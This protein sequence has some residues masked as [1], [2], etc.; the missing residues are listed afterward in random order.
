[1]PKKRQTPG[2]T[3]GKHTSE[4][5]FVR[6]LLRGEIEPVYPP[7]FEDLGLSPAEVEANPRSLIES[8]CGVDNSQEVEQYDG[9]LGVTVGF[10]ASN[11]RPVGQLQ[12]NDNL[13]SIYTNPGNV[14]GVR[15]GSGTLI[16]NDL[17]LTAGH[18]FDQTPGGWVVP[19]INGTMN[20]IS[21]ADIATNM[22]V[23]F[24]Y[25]FAAN[26]TLQMGQSFAV[27]ALVEY[28]LNGL[29][30]AIVRV[31][32]NPGLT[33][34][35]TQVALQDAG[36]GN[37]LCIMQHPAGLPKR[38]EAG[39]LTDFAGDYMRYSDI[40]TLGGSSGSGI[41][42]PT[43][44]IVGVHTNGGCT[45]SMTGYNHGVR[46]SAIRSASATIQGLLTPVKVKPVFDTPIIKRLTDPP[47]FK[48]VLDDPNFKKIVDDPVI[49]KRFADIPV[50]FDPRRLVRGGGIFNGGAAPFILATPHHA[51]L[52]GEAAANGETLSAGQ[53]GSFADYLAQ[54]EH[55]MQYSAS[56]LAQLEALYQSVLAQVQALATEQQSGEVAQIE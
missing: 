42:G 26:G 32:G 10:V 14:S 52:G 11:E 3:Q 8:L 28:R 21:S 34:G 54:I 1:M 16:A 27:T 13:A 19:R 4:M 5:E 39:P 51:A 29:D 24:N 7:H 37:I 41:L 38:I 43:G 36:P 53:A 12:W 56:D 35:T 22:H 40:D 46:I 20:P 23:N 31:A 48:K 25:Q 18:C 6:A 15:W 30:F 33:Y 17:F 45:S 2:A 44:R 9:T 55:A 49:V 47:K 50:P